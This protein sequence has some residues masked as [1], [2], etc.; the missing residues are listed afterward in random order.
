MP[1]N[2]ERLYLTAREKDLICTLLKEEA[3]NLLGDLNAG[4]EN[5]ILSETAIRLLNDAH[6][7]VIRVLRKVEAT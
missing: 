7:F 2:I 4:G 1:R 3:D 6:D 5:E